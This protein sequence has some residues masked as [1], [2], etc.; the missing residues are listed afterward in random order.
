MLLNLIHLKHR[1]DRLST[2]KP[3]LE[4]QGISDYRIWDGVIHPTSTNIGIAQAHQQIVKWAQSTH[5]KEVLIAED[6]LHFTAIGSFDYYIKNKPDD[7]DLYL[8]GIVW[9][10]PNNNL[11]D[12]FS[13]TTLYMIH[14]KFY[15]KFLSV[16]GEKDLDRSLKSKG[17]FV[18]CN[19]MV[20]VQH[21]GFSDHSNR[22]V[23]FQ[24]YIRGYK[25]FGQ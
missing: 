1:T 23:D 9:G 3:E 20:V 16:S 15:D 24:T 18:V 6:D 22:H 4:A 11:V 10:K 19:P 7:Y 21:N 17:K 25:L 14:E 13:G 5:Q 2:L 8:G 12:D